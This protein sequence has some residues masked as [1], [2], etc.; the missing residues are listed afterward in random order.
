M[1]SLNSLPV[2]LWGNS[3][4]VIMQSIYWKLSQ[5]SNAPWGFS[6]SVES[7]SFQT[8]GPN[9]NFKGME[10][11]TLCHLPPLLTGLHFQNS[12]N[13]DGNNNLYAN[14]ATPE[15]G[16]IPRLLPRRQKVPGHVAHW[17]K[18]SCYART[19]TTSKF[20]LG[21]INLTLPQAATWASGSGIKASG[22][23]TMLTLTTFGTSG[24]CVV[25]GCKRVL[26]GHATTMGQADLIGLLALHCKFEGCNVQGIFQHL[27]SVTKTVRNMTFAVDSFPRQV[28]RAL[29][30][31][32]TAAGTLQ[33]KN[34]VSDQHLK[35]VQR[36][37]IT[38][39][40]SNRMQSGWVSSHP[41]ALT[42]SPIMFP[43]LSS[44][45]AHTVANATVTSGTWS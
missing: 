12:N 35:G 31:Q 20:A 6:S 29:L 28:S 32:N 23:V 7:H 44:M 26:F 22:H 3:E 19:D 34:A 17:Q 40:P 42:G 25:T 18:A 38:S 37:L 39:L 41:A 11:S 24:E 8:C 2:T 14:T 4:D 9:H 10:I 30:W 16:L 13:F 1:A 5:H 21:G 43:P 45:T 33:I 15:T 36:N 27:V